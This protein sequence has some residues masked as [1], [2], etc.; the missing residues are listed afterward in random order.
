MFFLDFL[1]ASCL[2]GSQFILDHS[3]QH[4][5]TV[6]ILSRM[7]LFL[8]IQMVG[9][10]AMASSQDMFTL[11]VGTESS[12]VPMKLNRNTV[13]LKRQKVRNP[14]ERETNFWKIVLLKLFQNEFV[15][16]HM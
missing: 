15:T 14:V 13:T 3:G 4:P 8:A 2:R 11:T 12:R 6:L 7:F 5:V 10:I 1:S 16:N 9:V